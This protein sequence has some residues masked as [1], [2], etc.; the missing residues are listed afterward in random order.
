MTVIDVASVSSRARSILQ[1]KQQLLRYLVFAG[2]VYY[3]SG[4]IKDYCN[5]YA[6]LAEAHAV[7]V[8]LCKEWGKWAQI[9][10]SENMT[11]IEEHEYRK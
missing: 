11:L 6:T 5:R 1:P 10:D 7:A 2:D 8:V 3:P 4:G 9:A